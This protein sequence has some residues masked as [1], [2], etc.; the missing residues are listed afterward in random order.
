MY[1][2]D[3]KLK[4]LEEIQQ[5]PPTQEAKREKDRVKS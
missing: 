5:K 2:Y 1:V 3:K 4:A